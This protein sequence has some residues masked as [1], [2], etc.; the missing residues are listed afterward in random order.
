MKINSRKNNSATILPNEFIDDYMVHANGEYVKVYLY[1]LRHADDAV[2][3]DMIADALDLT[4]ADV[5]R[6]LGYWSRAGLLTTSD[7]E[8]SP[9]ITNAPTVDA[10]AAQAADQTARTAEQTYKAEA[11]PRTAAELADDEEFA[12]LL[13]CLQ[14]YLSCV[15]SQ[16]DT[17][18]VIYMYD[19]LK[20]P[21]ELIEYLFE[22]CIQKGK[23]S[24]RYIES[25]ARD[26]HSKG[27]DTVEKAKA[28]GE[29]YASEVW[30]VMKALGI[31]GRAPGDEE[32]RLIEK[33]FKEYGFTTDIVKEACDRTLAATGKPS[34]KYADSILN[35]WHSENVRTAEDIEKLD[36]AHA[37]RAGANASNPRPAKFANF[38]QRDEDIDAEVKNSIIKKI[39][40]NN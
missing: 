9:E 20:M 12:E 2:T 22:L 39:A 29:V 30:G 34:F 25:I 37:E 7:D 31:S 14:R 27:I 6:A 26:W 18:S 17:D 11:K 21:R 38:E 19:V 16:R 32:Q 33:W 36:A 10:A 24:L 35:R 8:P 40:S 3:D 1:C 5:T 15:F 13:Y 23:T 28:S 4:T